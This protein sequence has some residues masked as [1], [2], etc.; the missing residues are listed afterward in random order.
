MRKKS[1]ESTKKVILKPY[2]SKK[3]R[4]RLKMISILVL[5]NKPKKEEES[6]KKNTKWK[7]NLIK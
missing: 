1:V 7:E 3:S 4:L 5:K 2:K 6:M